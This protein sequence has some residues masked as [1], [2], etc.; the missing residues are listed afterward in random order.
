MHDLLTLRT[1]IHTLLRTALPFTVAHTHTLICHHSK[2]LCAD[3]HSLQP[4]GR[5]GFKTRYRDRDGQI[6]VRVSCH[7]LSSAQTMQKKQQRER[8]ESRDNRNISTDTL[9]WILYVSLLLSVCKYLSTSD[10]TCFL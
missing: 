6:D 7:L 2:H 1:Q 8:A 10:V 3:C 9:K 4:P 5:A